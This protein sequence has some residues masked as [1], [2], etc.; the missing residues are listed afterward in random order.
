MLGVLPVF[1]DTKNRFQRSGLYSMAGVAGLEPTNAG[2]RIQCLT[3]LAI[4]LYEVP[5]L[6]HNNEY[7]TDKMR[8]CQGKF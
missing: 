1:L 8:G 4:P 2:F 6:N 7:Y 5:L 3:N